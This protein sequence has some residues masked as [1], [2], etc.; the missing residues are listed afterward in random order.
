[1]PFGGAG[2]A[3]AHPAICS[4]ATV[5]KNSNSQR[6]R[7]SMGGNLICLNSGATLKIR[8]KALLQTAT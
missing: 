1:M 4:S 3:I 8:N 6:N 5:W 2:A 7:T